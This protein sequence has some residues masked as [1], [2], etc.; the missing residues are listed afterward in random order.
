MWKRKISLS[1]RCRWQCC[2]DGRLRRAGGVLLEQAD[3]A[4]RLRAEPGLVAP[5]R[6]RDAQV[7]QQHQE[8]CVPLPLFETAQ[9]LFSCHAPPQRHGACAPVGTAVWPWS[10]A[11]CCA[12][13]GNHKFPHSCFECAVALLN[14]QLPSCR[15]PLGLLAQTAAAISCIS[16]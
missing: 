2:R 7:R 16:V 9:T 3:Q 13:E 6:P 4:K 11:G 10:G 5:Q 15:S 14:L 8:L 1:L 12:L